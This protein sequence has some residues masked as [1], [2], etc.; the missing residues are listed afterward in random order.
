[1]RRKML[2]PVV[3]SILVMVFLT[4]SPLGSTP[5]GAVFPGD[6]GKI[7]FVSSR[8]GNYD[9][10]SMN[11]DGSG[12]TNLTGAQGIDFHPTW[13]PDGSKIALATQRDGNFEIYVMDADGGNQAR[14]TSHAATDYFPA[15]SPDGSKI[16]FT[17]TRNGGSD[18]WV[19]NADGSTQTLLVDTGGGDVAPTWSP[20]GSKIAFHSDAGG[21]T[22]V[23]VAGADGSAP[24]PV[25]ALGG[26][27]NPDWSPDGTKI[28]FVNSQDVY[29]VNSDGTGVTNLTNSGS[30]ELFAN[31]S[32]DGSKI[33][34]SSNASGNYDVWVMSADGTGAV[35]LTADAG[36]DWQSDWQRLE[37]QG[38]PD[39]P[40]DGP[41]EPGPADV[42]VK[43]VVS[44]PPA[45]RAGS[46]RFYLEVANVGTVP[47]S[48][49]K[50]SASVS[51]DGSAELGQVVRLGTE[52][53][54]IDPGNKVKVWF[55]W[56]Y[57]RASF[58]RGSNVTFSGSAEIVQNDV[59]PSNNSDSQTHRAV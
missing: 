47:V 36:F 44:G 35:Q 34:Y 51:V 4:L 1:M 27:N 50:I 12:Q 19:M 43:M 11:P 46:K 23:Y 5:A 25:T 10:W 31:W 15:W 39:D 56:T 41:G 45:S 26:A 38:S 14:L 58:A 20:D 7:A 9:V 57:D 30:T 22:E 33:H 29:V 18:I 6:N 42:S 54:T 40:A 24:T 59:E 8:S 21:T 37:K 55:E 2:E 53:M 28:T 3:R 48:T 13:S 49:T 16:A 52:E 32:P 17:S